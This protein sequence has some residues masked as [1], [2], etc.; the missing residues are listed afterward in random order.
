MTRRPPAPRL[1]GAGARRVQLAGWACRCARCG[2]EW[3]SLGDE[4]PKTCARC[5]AKFW[6]SQNPVGWPKGRKRKPDLVLNPDLAFAA[7][8]GQAAPFGFVQVDDPSDDIRPA[9]E[10]TA[11]GAITSP[12]ITSPP[13]WSE[14]GRKRKGGGAE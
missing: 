4:P 2:H 6:W 10:P 3:T 1:L 7:A 12:P 8:I 14:P 9:S 11:D 5:K 13:M